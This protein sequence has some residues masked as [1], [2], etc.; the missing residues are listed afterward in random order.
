MKLPPYVVADA[1]RLLE[2]RIDGG[3]LRAKMLAAL[4]VIHDRMPAVILTGDKK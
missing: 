1:R 4:L 2:T 3:D